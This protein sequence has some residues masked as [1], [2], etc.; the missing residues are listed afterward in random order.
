MAGFKAA[1]INEIQK[2]YKK[3]KALV[4]VIVSLVLIIIGQLGILALRSGFGLRGVSS[5]DFPLFVLSV[6]ASTII[7]L[8][9]A[10]VTIDSFSGEFSYNT[11][12]ITLTR[13][14][15]RFKIFT[16]K[17]VA[18]ILFIF[19]NLLFVMLFSLIAGILF[20]S[21]SFT[22]H[23]FIRIIVSYFVTLLPMMVLAMLIALFTNIFKS[24]VSVFFLSILVFIIFKALEIVFSRY[25]GI[26]FTS[27]MNW[28][29]LWIMDT[30]P[31]SKII[32]SFLMMCS[33]GI[34]LFT[35]GYYLFDKKEF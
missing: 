24:G 17:L 29:T 21:N 23:G 5:M 20:N 27:F 11:M 3:K 35:G 6:V 28:Y 1:L 2:L 19:A 31:L 34:L 4:A 8:F 9:T 30:F 13:P 32:R 15:T 22:L 33:Y 16:A 10:L 18:I 14:V 7:P 12:K 25:S 26:F